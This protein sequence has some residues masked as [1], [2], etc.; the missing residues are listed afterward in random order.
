MTNNLPLLLEQMQ[1]PLADLER[2]EA[3]YAANPDQEDYVGGDYFWQHKDSIRSAL[4][5]LDASMALNVQ[6]VEA[7]QEV[8]SI[9]AI[10]QNETY[11]GIATEALSAAAS[12]GIKPK[13]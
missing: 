11:H 13:Q 2:L 7:L 1:K 3:L 5:A 9:S 10:Y 4:A 12:R 6:L 8:Q